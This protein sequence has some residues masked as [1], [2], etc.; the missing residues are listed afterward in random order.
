MLYESINLPVFQSIPRTAKTI[1]D[2][3]CGTGSLGNKI[4]ESIDC[5]IVVITYS[6][7]EALIA[8]Q[9]LDRVLV[10][11]IN[12]LDV[13]KIGSFD[14]VICSHILEHL[15]YPDKLISSLKANLNVNGILIVALPNVLLWKQR[16]QF[17]KG[18]FRY[19]DGGLMDSTH[20]R[21]FDWQTSHELL[22]NSGYKI[23]NSQ[24]H[25]CFPLPIIRK[26]V[27]L[28]LSSKIDLIATKHLPGLFGSQFVFSCG[29]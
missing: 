4:K 2:I 10:A 9:Y 1:L 7:S 11:D 12:Q 22:E 25:G 21:F 26:F 19:T 18:R 16:W 8:K 28:N 17:L 29:L 3:G 20:F 15:N 13:N 6:E 14:C 27:P 5:K 23:I 24:A